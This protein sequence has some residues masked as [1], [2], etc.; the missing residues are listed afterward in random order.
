VIA[1]PVRPKRRSALLAALGVLALVGTLF[2]GAAPAQADDPSTLVI[3]VRIEPNVPVAA[4]GASVTIR[5]WNGT[6]WVV[7]ETLQTD[8]SGNVVFTGI[9][10][11]TPYLTETVVIGPYAP[12]WGTDKY[13]QPDLSTVG[14]ATGTMSYTLMGGHTV[15]ARPNRTLTGSVALPNGSAP[16]DGTVEVTI[17]RIHP[18][19]IVPVATIP[20]VGGAY[21][22][23]DLVPS[24]YTVTVNASPTLGVLNTWRLVNLMAGS[25]GWSLARPPGRA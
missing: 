22:L 17:S 10:Q 5:T 25:G 9:P 14:S 19:P 18:P 6:A 7:R 23:T 1:S 4:G 21:S 3:Y 15:V 13:A 11:G 20:V 16:P 12:I 2:A 8:A 24:N